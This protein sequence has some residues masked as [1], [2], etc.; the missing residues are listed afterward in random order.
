LNWKLIKEIAYGPLNLTPEQLGKLTYAEFIDLYEGF[1]WREKRKLE[2]LAR[3][4]AWVMSPHYKNPIDPNDLLKPA[5]EKKK[6]TQEEKEKVTK[7]I[8]ERLGVR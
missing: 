4:A 2:L 3:H 1:N 7:E 5:S 8:E 6:V